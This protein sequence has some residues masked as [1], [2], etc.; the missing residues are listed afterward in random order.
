MLK[1]LIDFRECNPSNV[2]DNGNAKYRAA[3]DP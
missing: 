3:V 2:I 1:L